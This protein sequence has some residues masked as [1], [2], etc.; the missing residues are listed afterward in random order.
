[1]IKDYNLCLI[2]TVPDN[3]IENIL[4]TQQMKLN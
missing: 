3:A 2:K 1:M 4:I